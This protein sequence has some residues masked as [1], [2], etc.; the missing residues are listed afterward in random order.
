[1]SLTDM[2]ALHAQ[3]LGGPFSGSSAGCGASGGEC[4]R[5]DGQNASARGLLPSLLIVGARKSGTTALSALL[6]QHPAIQ[7]PDCKTNAMR[8]PARVRKTMC[9]W[10]KEVRFFSRGTRMANGVD[11]C[12][13]RSLYPC[14]PAPAAGAAAP[15]VRIAFDGS[16]DY[17]VMSNG[18]V[19]SM[20]TAL[21]KRAKLVALLRDPSDRFYSACNMAMNEKRGRGSPYSYTEFASSL[22]RW[23]ACADS[24]CT[25]ETQ[26]VSMFFEYGMYARHVRKFFEHFGRE[27]VLVESSEPFYAEAWPSVARVLAHAGIDAPLSFEATVRAGVSASASDRVPPGKSRN[28]GSRWGGKD[29]RGKLLPAE[30]CKLS[31]YYAAPNRNLYKLLGREFGWAD[32]RMADCNVTVLAAVSETYGARTTTVEARSKKL[33]LRLG[34]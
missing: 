4:G 11:L 9:V 5:S 18:A 31:W 32:G 13:Y 20:A 24:G 15:P 2:A 29:Y 17:L 14:V 21:G 22:D 10:D 8:W 1:M 19:A 6:A 26:V 3:G 23:L 28:S 7:M 25:A 33:K 12:W 30:R 27:R 34:L 16:P